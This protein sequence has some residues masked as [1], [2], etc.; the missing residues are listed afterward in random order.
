MTIK[1]IGRVAGS[2]CEVVG[3]HAIVCSCMDECE[4]VT[5]MCVGD[6]VGG[7]VCVYVRHCYMRKCVVVNVKDCA[8]ARMYLLACL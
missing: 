3:S 1:V 6:R 4:D 8:Y 2:A 7:N 5:E